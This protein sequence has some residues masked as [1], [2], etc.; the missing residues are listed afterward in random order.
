[1][2]ATLNKKQQQQQRWRTTATST[3]FQKICYKSNWFNCFFKPLIYI[4]FLLAL[5]RVN[6]GGAGVVVVVVVVHTFLRLQGAQTYTQR[7]LHHFSW[8]LFFL[9]LTRLTSDHRKCMHIHI[10]HIKLVNID[11]ESNIIKANNILNYLVYCVSICFSLRFDEEKTTDL[12][13]EW[14]GGRERERKKLR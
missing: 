7:K 1:M 6:I 14:K 9:A 3:S 2:G 12:N 8:V 4:P 5:N 10:E 13:D 11:F